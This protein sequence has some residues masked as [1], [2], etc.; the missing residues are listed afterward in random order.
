MENNDWVIEWDVS[1]LSSRFEKQFRNTSS[2]NCIFIEIEFWNIPEVNFNEKSITPK[3]RK[4]QRNHLNILQNQN[5]S[6]HHKYLKYFSNMLVL[7][8]EPKRQKATTK[9]NNYRCL[10]VTEWNEGRWVRRF[11]IQIYFR[12][13][14]I[15]LGVFWRTFNFLGVPERLGGGGR[16][17]PQVDKPKV[18]IL[19]VVNKPKYIIQ[20]ISVT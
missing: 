10:E 8:T 3:L 20:I 17:S 4:I 18:Q 13:H 16:S 1:K 7:M 2:W 19:S 15:I 5:C 6:I 9:R 14:T 12:L 11:R